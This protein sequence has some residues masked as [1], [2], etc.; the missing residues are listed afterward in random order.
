MCV[1][2]IWF[3]TPVSNLQLLQLKSELFVF[4]NQENQAEVSAENNKPISENG[5]GV[6]HYISP[7]STSF[8]ILPGQEFLFILTNRELYYSMHKSQLME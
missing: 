5:Y 6:S 4:H 2:D 8:K 7:W 3:E 1:R